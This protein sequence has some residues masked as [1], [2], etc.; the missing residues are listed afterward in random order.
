M[1]FNLIFVHR[2]LQ[3]FFLPPLN[4]LLIILF[5]LI[6][7]RWKSFLGKVIIMVGMFFI[8]AQSTPY[9]ANFLSKKIELPPFDNTQMISIQAFVV[10]GGGVNNNSAE[11]DANVVANSSTF[12]RLRYTAY[13]AKRYPD[14]LIIVTGGALAYGDSEA[15]VMKR[16]LVDEFGV[17]NPILTEDKAI[18]TNENALFVTQ[19]LHQYNINN[20]LIITQAYHARRAV[21]LFSKYG[22]KAYPGSTLYYSTGYYIKP[23]L[24]FL[25]SAGSMLQTSSVIHEYVGYW[26][27]MNFN[28]QDD[29]SEY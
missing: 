1:D 29:V 17:T 27:D 10:L 28:N 9:V 19:I 15:Q 6:L 23:V 7:M 18:T 14:K 4:G 20:V 5:G 2:L 26:Y 22:V 21:A 11:Y 8:Y 3:S 13:L 12:A 25:P 16:A 24:W